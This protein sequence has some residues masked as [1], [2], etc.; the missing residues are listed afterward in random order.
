[1]LKRAIFGV[2]YSL[3][4]MGKKWILSLFFVNHNIVS[5]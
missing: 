1:M 4:S 5:V 3:L 2:Q